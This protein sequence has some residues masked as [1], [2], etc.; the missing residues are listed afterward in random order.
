MSNSEVNVCE[1]FK[2]IFRRLKL[3]AS[4]HYFMLFFFFVVILLGS[5]SIWFSAVFDSTEGRFSRLV[6]NM[7]TLNLM[8]FSA[9]LLAATCFEKLMGSIINNNEPH[10]KESKHILKWLSLATLISI[11][12]IMI[13]Y[14]VGASY[15]T[16]F[17]CFSFIAWLI[18]IVFWAVANIEN[19]SYAMDTD[20]KTSSGGADTRP[21]SELSRGSK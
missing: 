20:V 6:N 21:A 12:L 15:G 14:G 7:N 5:V 17:S 8:A 13:L 10:D 1:L 11:I 2:E 16:D 9:P 3:I 4:N 19:P 18:S